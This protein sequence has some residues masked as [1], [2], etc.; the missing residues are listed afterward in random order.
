MKDLERPSKAAGATFEDAAFPPAP[1]SLGPGAPPGVA[2]VRLADLSDAPPL[3][4]DAAHL[5]EVAA[6]IFLKIFLI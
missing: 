4:V 2:W 3:V 5:M 6:E 1:A